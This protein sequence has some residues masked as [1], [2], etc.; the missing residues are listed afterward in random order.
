[1]DVKLGLSGEDF[2]ERTEQ[3]GNNYRAPLVAKS[4]L[5]LFWAALDDFMLKVL[6]FASIFSIIFDICSNINSFRNWME[7]PCTFGESVA[8][9]LLNKESMVAC[10]VSNII[11]KFK[12]GFLR[13]HCDAIAV[14]RQS[15]FP[16]QHR[17]CCCY[18]F[19]RIRIFPSFLDIVAL[20][21]CRF[22]Q[23]RT[24]SLQCVDF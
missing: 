10:I 21:R 13:W 16:V 17:L 3:F 22:H 12:K 7:F 18:E 5:R 4:F 19:W 9:L 6:I 20:F 14:A 2:P 1:M 15:L 23:F 8:K 24:L 11:H